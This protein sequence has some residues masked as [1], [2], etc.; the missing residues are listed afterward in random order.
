MRSAYGCAEIV[1]APLTASA[2]TNIK[3]LEALAMG[4][5]V[6]STPAGINGLELAPDREV[7]VTRSANE[8]AAKILAIS[9]NPVERR[10]LEAGGRNAALRYD[11]SQIARKQSQ[12]YDALARTSR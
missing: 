7:A 3:V 2:G 8:M 6:V 4:R 11:W 10:N 9:S 1:L 12:L 5:A